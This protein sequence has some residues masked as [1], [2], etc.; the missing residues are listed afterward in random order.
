MADAPDPP[1]KFYALKPSEFERVNAP[2]PA[3][4]MVYGLAAPGAATADPNAPIDVRDLIRQ[5]AGQGTVLRRGAPAPT[6][7]ANDVH[8]VLI[9][10]LARA[11]AA[12]LNNVAPP[13]RPLRR[14]RRDYLMLMLGG[15]AFIGGLY[16][17]EL[18]FGF[19]VQCMA[20]QMPDEFG[21]LVRFALH[22]PAS[23]A[24]GLVGMVFFTL[25]I[26]WLMYGVM[27]NY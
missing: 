20:A 26:T 19:Q 14:R 15:N 9:E 11:D 8:A 12:G 7:E 27:D 3:A 24:M 2:V 13:T 18:L 22:N 5:G 23:Y 4:R 1:R 6:N 21:N 16:G 10:N 25:C 17:T